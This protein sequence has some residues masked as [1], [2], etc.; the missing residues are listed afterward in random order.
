MNGFRPLS[1]FAG[2]RVRAPERYDFATSLGWMP[3]NDT[4]FHLTA[5]HLPL[6]VRLAG[7]A[8]KLGALMHPDFASTKPV[9][10]DGRWQAGY[11]PIALRI[12]PFVLGGRTGPRPIDE[13]EVHAGCELFGELGVA[14]SP[15]PAQ[16]TL[17]P[18]LTAIRNTLLML[19]QGGARL[20]RALDLLAA[21]DLLA[22]LRGPD[23]RPVRDL[24]IDLDRLNDLSPEAAAALVRESFLPLDIAAALAF[25][26][27][28]LLPDRLPLPQ[29]RLNG[30]PMPGE[31]SATDPL[32][33]ALAGLE[34]A[35]FALD[36]SD[37]F[38]L[39]EL[40]GWMTTPEAGHA[41]QASEGRW[42]VA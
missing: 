40:E 3:V 23:S 8:P 11:K 6:T 4:E 20:T 18:E 24:T 33:F 14:V 2:L 38:D 27:R 37:L 10:G 31:R 28:H 16:G 42:V 41:P 7:G 12:Y 32:D 29:P 17:G 15:E 36:G 26:R 9:A 25:S 19:R 13:I 5:H 21:A 35:N 39:S 22:P 30:A 1:D 34:A